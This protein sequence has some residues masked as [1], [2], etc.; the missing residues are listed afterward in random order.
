MSSVSCRGMF[1]RRRHLA[2]TAKKKKYFGLMTRCRDPEQ[3]PSSS[4]RRFD[5]WRWSKEAGVCYPFKNS[6]RNDLI[7]GGRRIFL[8]NQLMEPLKAFPNSQETRDR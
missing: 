3:A 7:L 8:C 6:R 4:R 5:G 1:R 2:K